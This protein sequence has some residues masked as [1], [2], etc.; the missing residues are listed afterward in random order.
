[1]GHKTKKQHYIPQFLLRNFCSEEKVWVF[2]KSTGR[3]YP[4]STVNT[5]HENHFYSAKNIDDDH[6]DF[7][8]L[9][10]LMDGYGSES[11]SHIIQKRLLPKT[12][13]HL[14]KLAFF[15][16]LQ[17]E[18]GPS[19]RSMLEFVQKK[20]IE[21]WG[22]D[23]AYEGDSRTLGQYG[24]EDLKYGSILA[25]QN[26]PEFAR[27]LQQ[28]ALFL[29]EAPVGSSFICSDHPVVLHNEIDHSPRGSLGIGKLGIEIYFPISPALALQFCCPQLAQSMV[30]VPEL[31]SRLELQSQGKP[32]PLATENVTFMNHLQV[33]QS[34]R[35]LFARNQTDFEL[36]EEM[37]R[38]H[39][40]LKKPAA[41]RLISN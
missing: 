28:K 24:S 35:F 1:V 3:S 22:A 8:N 37:I 31:R 7:E 33:T 25:L 21:K 29:L 23:I 2:D 16:A 19:T 40:E 39:P 26:V 15:T 36:A 34:D 18:R 13:E 38:D 6:V 27:I 9:T 4:S 11:I 20:I 5:G 30:L 10:Q 41:H 12:D 32:I 14:V 17:M